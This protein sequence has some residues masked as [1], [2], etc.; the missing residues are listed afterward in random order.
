MSALV[1][2]CL[3]LV[4]A[5]IAGMIPSRNGHRRRAVALILTAPPL[6]A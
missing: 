4:A 5:N 1:A 2:A 6:D 3:W